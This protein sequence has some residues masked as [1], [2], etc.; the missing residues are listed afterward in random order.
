M[1]LHNLLTV[2]VMSGRVQHEMKLA[3]ATS[4]RYL[5]TRSG[6]ETSGQS[7][8]VNTHPGTHGVETGLQSAIWARSSKLLMVLTCEMC[9]KR[10]D[11]LYVIHMPRN[12]VRSLLANLQVPAIG[13]QMPLF[14]HGDTATQ[15]GQ[16]L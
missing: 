14:D 10:K 15:V 11:G 6:S 16:R 4:A 5:V 2:K 7:I 1:Y 3:N 13:S 12:E 9:I 8:L